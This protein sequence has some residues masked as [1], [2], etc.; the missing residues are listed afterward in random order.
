MRL[1]PGYAEN[2]ILHHGRLDPGVT[3]LSKP[4]RASDLERSVREILSGVGGEGFAID[5]FACTIDPLEV[6]RALRG[7]GYVG[8]RV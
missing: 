1:L 3:L 6:N 5:K 2:A 8:G 4:F 7:K